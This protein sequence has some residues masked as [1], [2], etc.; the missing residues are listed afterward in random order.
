MSR[1]D[2]IERRLIAAVNLTIAQKLIGI[3]IAQKCAESGL[4]E[5][6]LTKREIAGY[7]RVN[8]ET[9]EA[10]VRVLIARGYFES[11]FK[12]GGPSVFRTL[13]NVEMSGSAE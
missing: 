10:A 7:V 4:G 13:P 2:I 5:T 6:A 8:V 11:T 9:V 12:L 3:H 1:R